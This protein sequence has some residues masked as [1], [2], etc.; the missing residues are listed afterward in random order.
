[1]H[2]SGLRKRRQ[3][4]LERL[5]EEIMVENCLNLG[6]EIDIQVQ[7]TQRVPSKISPRKIRLRHIIVKIVKIKGKERILKATRKKCYY[8]E[9][10][11]H[12]AILVDF[13]TETSWARREWHEIFKVLKG[14]NFQ[15]II[16]NLTRLSFRI[17]GKIEFSR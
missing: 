15:T 3:R 5:F 6:K 9:E 2:Y 13:S 14:N 16:L 17:G 8:V 4:S 11:P 7:E 1:M 12:K 10:K